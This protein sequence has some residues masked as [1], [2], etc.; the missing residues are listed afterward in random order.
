MVSVPLCMSDLVFAQWGCAPVP[1]DLVDGYVDVHVVDADV[2]LLRT[3]ANTRRRLRT[4]LQCETD[5]LR[6]R[7]SIR[8]IV[9]PPRISLNGCALPPP[10]C[11]LIAEFAAVAVTVPC[12]RVACPLRIYAIVKCSRAPSKCEQ[13]DRFQSI[14]KGEHELCMQVDAAIVAVSAQKN[15]ARQEDALGDL[16]S[17]GS[18]RLGRFKRRA[19]QQ[20][21]AGAMS[22]SA[23]VLMPPSSR[24]PHR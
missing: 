20:H 7:T 5:L 8:N 15:A 19:T 9:A 13:V 16:N 22:P 3:R 12:S 24:L 21:R 17:L 6:M 23:I 10:C 1:V 11:S 2:E 14:I 4:L 18:C